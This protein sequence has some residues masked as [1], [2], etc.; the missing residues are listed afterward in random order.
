M[1]E[2]FKNIPVTTTECKSDDYKN[3]R[4]LL[5]TY[6]R[7]KWYINKLGDKASPNK[8]QYLVRKHKIRKTI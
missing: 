5:L 7:G 3:K 8:I 1:S 4:Q 2:L 6:I